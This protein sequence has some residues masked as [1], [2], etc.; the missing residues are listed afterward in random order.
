MMSRGQ[1]A[2]RGE[3][4]HGAR[5]QGDD[6]LLTVRVIPRAARETVTLEPE[7]VKAKLTAPPVDGKAN[8]ALCRLL[9]PLFGVPKSRVAV[10]RGGGSRTKTV[11][12]EAPAKLP[13]FLCE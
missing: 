1:A 12:I 5:W 11:R 13:D 10:V 7:C 3:P 9:G 8:A 6:L 4:G 2:A